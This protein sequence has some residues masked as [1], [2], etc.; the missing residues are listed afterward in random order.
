MNNPVIQASLDTNDG[1]NTNKY[2]TWKTKKTRNTVSIEKSMVGSDA[3][4]GYTF[5]ISYKTSAV[6]LIVKSD[7]SLLG[8]TGKKK[9]YLKGKTSLSFVNWVFR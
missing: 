6:L 1:A 8:D 3:H 2:T 4:E 7:R 5:A 9:F